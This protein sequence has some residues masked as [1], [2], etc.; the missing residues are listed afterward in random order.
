MSKVLQHL[1]D[2]IKAVAIVTEPDYP[3]IAKLNAFEQ[4]QAIE[5]GQGGRQAALQDCHT[6]IMDLRL[7]LAAL[8]EALPRVVELVVMDVR[9]GHD[10]SI[11]KR[12][13]TWR[14]HLDRGSNAWEDDADPGVA[15]ACVERPELR[16][17]NHGRL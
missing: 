17:C 6:T 11:Y 9:R 14:Y 13:Q 3:E 7:Q 2:R 16:R 8:E 12:G 5:Q 1:S 10:P 4:L 15:A